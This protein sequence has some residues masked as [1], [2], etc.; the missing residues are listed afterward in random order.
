MYH[1]I[2]DNG[3]HCLRLF[4]KILWCFYYVIIY[5]FNLFMFLTI[6][7]WDTWTYDIL[8]LLSMSNYRSWIVGFWHDSLCLLAFVLIR[9]RLTEFFSRVSIWPKEIYEI[10]GKEYFHH[11]AMDRCMDIFPLW[12]KE[13]SKIVH[14]SQTPSYAV[15]RYSG[16]FLLP[17]PLPL[18][19]C[20]PLSSVLLKPSSP[21]PCYIHHHSSTSAHGGRGAISI[22]LDCFIW[23]SVLIHK[24][25]YFFSCL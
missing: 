21:W 13:V 20:R 24:L 4:W 11:F 8:T 3:R 15:L 19:T 9:S 1:V 7:Q 23:T 17:R 16:G 25:V 18:T 2:G 6:I 12:K 10:Y 5:Y 14:L 22:P